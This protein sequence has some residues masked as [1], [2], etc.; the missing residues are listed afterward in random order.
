MTSFP[1]SFPRDV[2]TLTDGVV[3]LR[4]HTPDDVDALYEQATDSVMLR[5]TTVPDPSTRETAREFATHLIPDGWR[6]EREW[7][8]AV[9]AP[10]SDGAPRFVGTVSLRNEGQ[11]RAEIAYGSH[12]WA[13]GRGYVVR[14]LHLLLDWGFEERGLRTVIWWAN[15]GNWASRKVAWRLGF[16]FDG[17]VREW[18]PQRG[19]LH[20][21]WVGAL[22][23]ADERRPRTPWF[24]APRIHG[25]RVVLRDLA[26]RDVPRI[27]EACTDRRTSY[28]LTQMPSP[29]TDRDALTWME[30]MREQRA[31]GS[32]VTWAVADP[33]DDRLLG[34]VTA[35]D[36]DADGSAE[37]GYWAHPEARGRGVTTE[38]CALAVR[39]SFVPEEDGGLGRRRLRAFAAEGNDASMWVLKT[40]GFVET[41]RFRQVKTMRDGSFLDLVHYDLLVSEWASRS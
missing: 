2:P 27:V 22:T 31:T 6:S 8:F 12:P 39:H 34:A 30:Q 21:G 10:D 25:E 9:D 18:L 17:T 15:K 37:I 29:Y 33:G 32:G 1:M 13:R 26:E 36:L 16:S 24:E 23:A 28:W 40:N 14:A 3:T 35:F 5:W 19:T 38:A 20:D 7:A 11:G 4:A 41:G